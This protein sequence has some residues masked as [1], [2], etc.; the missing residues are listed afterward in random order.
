MTCFCSTDAGGRLLLSRGWSDM[1][2][3][4]LSRH[5]TPVVLFTSTALFAL[6]MWLDL[7]GVI[8]TRLVSDFGLAI[9]ALGAAHRLFRAANRHDG[10]SAKGWRALGFAALSWGL[11]QTAWAA[12]QNLFGVSLPI[13]SLPD[14]GFLLAV[15]FWVVGTAWLIPRV[16]SMSLFR[17]AADAMI[18]GIAVLLAYSLLILDAAMLRYGS[19]ST[20]SFLALVYPAGDVVMIALAL[21]VLGRTREGDRLPVMLVAASGG[22]HLVTKSVYSVMIVT[23]TYQ[24][25]SLLDIGWFAAFALLW[26][27]AHQLPADAAAARQ[28]GRNEGVN[29]LAPYV[30]VVAAVGVLVLATWRDWTLQSH[31]VLLAAALLVLLAVR[32]WLAFEEQAAANDGWRDTARQLAEAQQVARI[33]SWH[34]LPATGETAWSDQIFRILGLDPADVSASFDRFLERVH[35][36]D[37]QVVADAMEQMSADGQ[38][39]TIEHRVTTTEGQMR[40]IRA[41]GRAIDDDAGDVVEL[42]GTLQDITEQKV[43]E[44]ALHTSQRLESLGR[45]A[46][47][48]AHD[49][50]NLLTIIRGHVELARVDND[51][52]DLDEAIAATERAAGLVEQ[53]LAFGRR[54]PGTQ[55]PVDLHAAVAAVA[56]MAKPITGA[57][58]PVV[59]QLPGN[60]PPVLADP[61]MFE[62]ILV[63]LIL[64]AVDA[65]PDGGTITI[66]AS[67]PD[68]TTR[69]ANGMDPG[70][71]LTVADTGTGMEPDIAAQ[72]FDPFFTTKLDG[73]GTGLGLASVHGTVTA[74]GGSVD[75]DTAPNLGTSVHLV[76]PAAQ[77]HPE[78]RRSSERPRPAPHGTT[79][80]LVDD[81]PQ[82]ARM[83]A[84]V[85]RNAGYEVLTATSGPHAQAIATNTRVDVL[86]TDVSMPL[87]NGPSL[88]R[89]MR[90][91]RPALPVVYVSAYAA[92]ALK[93]ETPGAFI[94]KP[95]A[96]SEL[97]AAVATVVGVGRGEEGSPIPCATKIESLRPAG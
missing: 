57:N 11:G 58:V 63:N 62:Q 96:S 7:G 87:M 41:T 97:L 94:K 21:S 27:A 88:A 25:G 37:R 92:D 43:A 48:V 44:T 13:G 29:Q 86:V 32:Q 84:A 56:S 28:Q 67:L 61:A 77:E 51:A 24:T 8:A 54:Q 18:A 80:L 10:V 4:K 78:Q 71:R 55:R 91:S 76:L 3:R 6:W 17:I 90:T 22:V 52:G 40:W 79:V 30:P 64:N 19:G 9:V 66:S 33:G 5:G 2:L 50:N 26:M 65:M 75:I 72:A 59:C 20:L 73:K 1:T 31:D 93:G 82:V 42:Q 69:V 23:G 81:E 46:G 95:F 15:P 47:G 60:L 16:P 70:I 85:L 36:S 45:L 35:P 53:L 34:R 38:P 39:F 74:W 14:V 68:A 89:A 83:T 12:Q 49:F